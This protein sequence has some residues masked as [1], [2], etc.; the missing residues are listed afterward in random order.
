MHSCYRLE[1]PAADRQQELRRN[2]HRHDLA[3][4]RRQPWAAK[5]PDRW[6]AVRPSGRLGGA[7]TAIAAATVAAPV[8]AS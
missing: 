7:A 8:V 1:A 4:G 3:A 2:A 5:S 6:A